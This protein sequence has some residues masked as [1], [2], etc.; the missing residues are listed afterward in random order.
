MGAASLSSGPFPA[1]MAA[2]KSTFMT[3]W[4]WLALGL[5]LVALEMAASGGFYVIFFGIAALAIGGLHLL[6]IAGPVW[7]Q[8]MLFS[9]ISVGS[10]L[11][12][13][14]P[15]LRMLSPD[16]PSDVD[17]MVGETAIP[18]EDIAPGAV[19]R[20]ELRGTVWSARNGSAAPLTRG[21]RCRVTKVERLI[22]HL[23]PEGVRA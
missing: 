10:L 20:A 19:G 11:L 12:F 5:I 15:V 14:K 17:S 2:L 13:R 6:D 23:E 4:H 18:I 3:W 7:L 8:L 21:Q 9:V 16:S 1:T 22:I